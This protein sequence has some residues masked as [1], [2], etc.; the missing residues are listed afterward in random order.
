MEV[1]LVVSEFAPWLK[2]SNV[3]EAVASFSKTLKQ[4]G[5]TVTVVMPFTEAFEHAGMLLARRLSK[6]TFNPSRAW[7][8]YDTQLSSGVQLV[9]V[10]MDRYSPA[11]I[12][13]STAVEFAQA[14]AA[15]VNDRSNLGLHTDVVHVH[16]LLGSLTAVCLAQLDGPRPPTIMT[17]Y[18]DLGTSWSSH[19]AQAAEFGDYAAL[20]ELS[21][22]GE[23]NLLAAAIR[24]AKCVT[25]P[26]YAHARLL[27]DP[28]Q[29]GPLAGE[30]GLL[31]P[32]IVGIPGGVDYAQANPASNP[33]LAA[34]YDAEDWSSKGSCKTNWQRELGLDVALEC[35]LLFIAGP[36]CDKTYACVVR[37]VVRKLLDYSIGV[38]V[39]R[40]FGESEL[41]SEISALS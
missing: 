10:E 29:S 26:S 19:S 15:L 41:S 8:V 9:L 3:A 34:R 14:V 24:T 12:S 36:L 23:L 13:P 30:L 21:I 17:V 7:T 28:T 35:P 6:L 18:D 4:V 40:E 27:M 20:P 31:V 38:V 25:V 1:L 32:P 11:T 37:D 2:H 5:H 33:A 16:G 39:A 22:G